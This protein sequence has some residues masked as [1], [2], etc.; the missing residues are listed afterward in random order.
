[1][2]YL[3]SSA[4]SLT[5]SGN[6]G[7][8]PFLTLFVLGLVE[9]SDPTLLNMGKTMESILASWYSITILGLLTLMELIAKCVPFLDEMIDSVEVFIV[10]VL[11]ILGSLGTLGLLDL[12]AGGENDDD[13]DTSE[14]EDG[15]ERSLSATSGDNFLTFLKISLVVVGIGLSLCIHLFKMIIRVTGLV[16][17]A[18]LCQPCLTILEVT[19]VCCGVL[20]AIF[21]RQI[22]IVTCCVL[23]TCA[24]YAIQRKWCRKKVGDD[25][26]DGRTT[27]PNSTAEDRPT[28]ETNEIG[29]V[30]GVEELTS[31]VVT[32]IDDGPNDVK[33]TSV[34]IN[35]QQQR[36]YDEE[37]PNQQQRP[38]LA[39]S[40]PTL[41]SLS[42]LT[43]MAPP[44]TNP[45]NVDEL[46]TIAVPMEVSKDKDP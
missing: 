1:M 13:N 43:S 46:V 9:V 10:P 42:E 18:G 26:E 17:C 8:S 22:A 6:T 38:Q 19:A 5:V 3:S 15:Q 44:G 36:F 35:Q 40:L 33:G 45:N 28:N 37:N 7:I 4:V 20:V 30:V 25:D 29:I 34:P 14:Q 23:L 12:V 21:I 27:N 11:S 24:I 16:C 31:N 41:I 32:S 2:D 39:E